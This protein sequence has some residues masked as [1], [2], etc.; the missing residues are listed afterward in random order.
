MN[1]KS[2]LNF[3]LN[4]KIVFPPSKIIH[5]GNIPYM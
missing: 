5:H 4:L 1:G 2:N 3:I